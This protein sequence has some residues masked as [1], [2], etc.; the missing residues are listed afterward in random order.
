MTTTTYPNG[1]PLPHEHPNAISISSFNLLAPLYIRPIDART[2]KVQP[3]ASF[4]WISEDDSDEILGDGVRLPKLLKRL[5]SCE[6]DFICVQELQLERNVNVSSAECSSSS[7]RG[8]RSRKEGC[9][10]AIIADGINNPPYA[11]PEWIKPLVGNRSTA[12]K[13][14][15]GGYAVMLPEQSELQKMGERNQRVLQKDAAVTNAIFYRS[16]KWR[17]ISSSCSS[18][19]TTNCV[20]QAFVSTTDEIKDT[21]DSA[22]PDPI[23]IV[24]IHLDAKSEEKR[25]QQ[26]QR[27][28]EL[29]A[30]C[31]QSHIPPIIIAGDYNCELFRGSCVHEFLAKDGN[32]QFT[33]ELHNGQPT[34]QDTQYE[35][36]K[37]LRLPADSTPDR[38]QMESWN[39]LRNNVSNFIT[40]NCLVLKRLDTGTTRVAYNHD[41]ELEDDAI[42]ETANS[43]NT[44]K[45]RDMEQ[46]HL[47]HIMYTSLTLDPVAKWATLEGDA[48][49]AKSGLP[50]VNV[51]T[52]H[53]PIAAVFKLKTHPRL[54][55]DVRSKLIVSINELEQRHSTQLKNLQVDLDRTRL[56]LEQNHATMNDSDPANGQKKKKAKTKPPPEIIDHIRHSRAAKKELKGKHRAE[57]HGLLKDLAVLERME[58]QM[59]FN[60]LSCRSWAENGR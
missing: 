45:K 57:R 43:S 12:D 50:N 2:G 26:V 19:S 48:Y 6:S 38:D 42:S 34:V 4:D 49:S 33:Y 52:D 25:V 47:D 8:R 32:E 51:P 55:E 28:L 60:G 41:D 40:D 39:A 21:N 10:V 15:N 9:G 56:E 31:S 24:S 7:Q 35:C 18:G 23:V 44:A 54:D 17:P 3:F 29:C 27:C 5:Q 14:N 20:M 36:S 37:A 13:R 30:K 53:L 1:P 22:Q 11:L 58:L 59:Y 46:W 16:D